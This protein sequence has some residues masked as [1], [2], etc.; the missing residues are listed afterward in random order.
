MNSLTKKWTG[1]VALSCVILF[2]EACNLLEEI[3]LTQ[4]D[5]AN[6]YQNEQDALAALNG[7]YAS[8]KNDNGYYRQVWLSNL[9]AAS[10]QGPSSF[11]HG[12]FRTGTIANT[13]PNLP[14]SWVS[15]YGAIRNANNV[16]AK[17]PG[18]ENINDTLKNR[19]VGEARFL[20]GLHYLNLVRAF[21]EVPLRIEPLKSNEPSGLPVSDIVTIYNQIIADFQFASLHCWEK[22][23]PLLGY[24]NDLGRVTKAAAHAMLTKTYLHIASAKRTASEG[25]AGNL[26]YLTF[27]AS[28]IVYYDLAKNHADTVIASAGF[29][30]AGSFDEWKT[31]FDANNGNNPEMIFEVQGSSL[32]EQGTALAN[33][34]SPR[35][36]GLSGGGFGGVNRLLPRFI[37]NHVNK[38]DPRF[39]QTILREYQDQL[40]RHVLNPEST[41]YLRFDLNTGEEIA[42][43]LNVFTAKYID[44]SATTEYTSRQNYH[45]IRLADVYLMRA[46]AA[47]EISGSPLSAQSDFNILRARVNMT[48]FDASSMS[49]SQ[50]REVLLSE[51]AAELYMEGHRFFD[52]TRM[53]V[54]NEYCVITYGIPVG[55]RGPEDYTWP[56][57]LVESAAN[58]NI[59]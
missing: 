54:Y 24:I 25:K 43:L 59:N 19:I 34:F 7:A 2:F 55:I 49:M 58:P 8:L 13:D 41:G 48:P 10:D 31:I 50:F 37:N 46:E 44:P 35:E 36:A 6:F 47:A 17:V 52:L 38:F 23:Q 9:H 20:R 53:G 56:I 4:I 22:E 12:D 1:I 26:R 57:P 3:P 21:G 30:L 40:R 18:I 32:P 29:Q 27:P 33:L 39:A 28:P 15:I 45:I 51:R 11:Q 5:V 42:P 16:I 14:I